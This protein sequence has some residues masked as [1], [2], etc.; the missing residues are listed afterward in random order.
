MY[1]KTG[2]LDQEERRA[3]SLINTKRHGKI[4]IRLL[5]ELSTEG[6]IVLRGTISDSKLTAKGIKALN[7]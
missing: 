3:L 5:Q 4:S 7:K 6:L 2:K 1:S